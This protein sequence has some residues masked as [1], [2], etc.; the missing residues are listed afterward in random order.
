MVRV[1][2]LRAGK[3]YFENYIL[4]GDDIV[5]ADHAVAQSYRLLMESLGVK[6]SESKT[7]VSDDTFEFARR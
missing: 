6:I 2:A 3:P 1:A 4:L 5:I 7:H